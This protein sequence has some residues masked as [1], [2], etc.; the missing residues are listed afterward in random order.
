MKGE[1]VMDWLKKM[2][3]AISYIEENLSENISYGEIA[4]IA[5][6]SEYH[7]QRMFSFITDVSLAEYIRRRRLTLAALELQSS[8][9][10][11]IDLALK[12]GYESPEAFA[13]AFRN[14]HGVSPTFAREKGAQLKAYPPISF[15]ISIK[16]EVEMNYKI[17]EKAPFKFFGI[18]EVED[19]TNGNNLVR[20]PKF[21]QDC[22]KNGTIDRLNKVM[23]EAKL[24]EDATT[25]VNAI[26]CY[27]NTGE[28]T[29][30]YMIG[31]FDLEGNAEVPE[32]F[33]SISIPAYTW[34]VFRTE[35]HNED[36]TTKKIQE[37]WARIFPEWFLTSGYEHADGPE[38]EV[39]FDLSNGKCYSEVW[40]PIVKK[41]A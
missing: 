20:I 4:R 31:V 7:F 19:M 3:G 21:W 41:E 22:F 36:E 2:N 39:Y 26:M 38:L 5:C 13:R 37:V 16:G 40:I 33:T 17:V 23:P 28:D 6:C 9:I 15:H 12:Y 25:G 32:E 34:V 35:E 8:N 14:L 11:V 30:P 1:M 24:E 10:K 29:F 18:E 27:R